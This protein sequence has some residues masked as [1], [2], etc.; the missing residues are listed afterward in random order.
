MA[1]RLTSPRT[2]VRTALAGA[3]LAL[4]VLSGCRQ[5]TNPVDPN[6]TA[7]TG[8]TV[9]RNPPAVEQVIPSPTSWQSVAEHQNGQFLGLTIPDVEYGDPHF[10]IEPRR[11][12]GGDNGQ[13][14]ALIS[15]DEPID[16]QMFRDG[17]I[18]VSQRVPEGTSVGSLANDPGDD[19]NDQWSIDFNLNRLV[20]P[21]NVDEFPAID[22][23]PVTVTITIIDPTGVEVDSRSFGIL[24]GDVNGDG[25]VQHPEDRDGSGG[26]TDLDGFLAVGDAP[27]AEEL[28]R[29]DLDAN[30]VIS[31]ADDETV[32]LN[33]DGWGLPGPPADFGST[34]QSVP[35]TVT[36]HENGGTG[37]APV[38]GSSPYVPGEVVSILNEGA[39]T[40][41]PLVFASWNTEP[42]G[43]GTDFFATQEI[44]LTSA[45]DLYAQW[46]TEFAGGDGTVGTPYLIAT[47]AH[48]D[49]M[50]NYLT[51][52]FVLQ[53]DIDLGVA[54]F[55]A[56]LGWTPVGTAG[57]PFEGD[58]NGNGFSIRNMYVD[59]SAIG[60]GLFGYLANADVHGLFIV[61]ALVQSDANNVGVLAGAAQGGPVTVTDV[62][63]T[64]EV[65]TTSG[66]IN[67][68]G[69]VG[70]GE[71][72]TILRSFANV[73][74]IGG[75]NAGGLVGRLVSLGGST[76]TDS[77]AVGPVEALAGAGAFAGGLVGFNQ[78]DLTRT[79]AAGSVVSGSADEGGLV[80]SSGGGAY[81]DNYFDS[82]TTGQ[83]SAGFA[84]ELTT[85]AMLLQ[86]SFGGWPFG[87]TWAINEGESYPYLT[88]QGSTKI[89]E[90]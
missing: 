64:G 18:L 29:A 77:Y 34:E 68:G 7:F 89:P 54:Q 59:H 24:P 79:Y 57:T 75:E 69:L 45:L 62:G 40:N 80:G 46:E 9:D 48:L 6:S 58:L 10:F 3:L 25:I 42:D 13:I 38:D 39:L 90:P 17:L 67:A 52:Y 8:E 22:A 61:D 33:Y 43:T 87:I 28:I 36:Y 53:N 2:A 55:A 19:H 14:F 65:T 12:G 51:A 71:A 27:N 86:S 76:V 26:P 81:S 49:R 35:L 21:Y 82:S 5:L 84:T 85:S 20:I 50:R 88:W 44:V 66:S 41:L 31:A 74:T 60:A 70:Y 72:L 23:S 63:V 11:P 56:P 83:T 1:S 78:A 37:A 47:P 4:I 15:F 73:A 30:G 16:E 32:I